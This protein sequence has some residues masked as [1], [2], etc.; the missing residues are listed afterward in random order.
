MTSAN[1]DLI[2]FA[3]NLAVNLFLPGLLIAGGVA[4]LFR[5]VRGAPP[6]LRYIITVAAFLI[7]AFIPLAVTLN[8]S[9]GLD[10]FIET[11]QGRNAN[12]IDHNFTN[13]SSVITPEIGLAA[14]GPDSEKTSVDFLNK[15]AFIV[16]DSFIGTIL[17]SL[18]ISG[19]FCFLLRDILA[20]R[21]LRKA[22]QNWRRATN[23]ERKELAFPNGTALYI[24]EESPATVGLFRPVIV[25]PGRFPDDLSLASKHFI[26]QHE[27]AHARWRDPL[28][29]SLLRLIRS[30]FWISPALWLLECIAGAEQESAADHTAIIECSVHKSDFGATALNYATM[31]VLV[32]K[33]FNSLTQRDSVPPNTIALTNGSILESRIRRLLA[34]PSKP[35]R[36]RVCS[37]SIIFVSSLVGLFFIPVAFQS[38]E[39]KSQAEEAVVNNTQEQEKELTDNEN[40]NVLS[41]VIRRNKSTQATGK[42]DNKEADM[43]AIIS[44]QGESGPEKFSTGVEATVSQT[45]KRLQNLDEDADGGSEEVMRKL[46]EEDARASGMKKKLDELINTAQSPDILRQDLESDI[47]QARQ[48]AASRLDSAMSKNQQPADLQLNINRKSN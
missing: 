35:T 29:N 31:L 32:A 45:P 44:R 22:R 1:S 10:T 15:F 14:L 20:L 21:R 16:A 24:G 4:I 34:D 25:L 18:W 48:K 37:A 33:H 17:L 23:S 46:S 27:L 8:G 30:L 28:I 43:K 7:A 38:K 26:I 41:N 19:S 13:Q 9:I 3:V 12:S 11:R 39:V 6:R 47:A 40:L 36:L 2:L 5:L 42:D